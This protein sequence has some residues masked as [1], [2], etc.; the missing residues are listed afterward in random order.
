MRLS[1]PAHQQDL[2][3][4]HWGRPTRDFSFAWQRRSFEVG[5]SIALVPINAS[6]FNPAGE[7]CGLMGTIERCVTRQ[8]GVD[9]AQGFA[10]G[11]ADAVADSN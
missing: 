2:S 3:H 6:A 5:V 7:R 4:S 8:L 9:D 10:P 11:R 1:L